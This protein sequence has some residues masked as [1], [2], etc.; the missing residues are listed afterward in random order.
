MT[1]VELF[2]GA[3]GASLG[4]LRAGLEEVRAVEWNRDACETRRAAGLRCDEGDVRDPAH[5]TGVTADA[6][7]S[8]F[9]CQAWSTAGKRLGKDDPRNGWPWTVE[10][11]DRVRPTWFMGENVPGLTF[12]KGACVPGRCAEDCARLYFEGTILR[13]LGERF[14]WV[15]WRILDSARFGVPQNRERLYLVAGPRPIR[16]PEETHA[17]PDELRQGGL[18]GNARRPWVTVR[19][20]LGLRVQGIAT[21]HEA[22]VSIDSRERVDLMHR[23]APGEPDV[24]RHRPRGPLGVVEDPKHPHARPDAPAPTIRSGGA[25]HSSP[26]MWLNATI[27]SSQTSGRAGGRVPCESSIDAP[28]PTVRANEG[29]GLTIR[30]EPWDSWRDKHLRMGFGWYDYA[31]ASGHPEDAMHPDGITRRLVSPVPMPEWARG[32]SSDSTLR[33]MVYTID[34]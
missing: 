27:G 5:Y 10:V 34:G 21:A 23:P 6:V 31:M 8:S 30:I 12:H 17:P 9:P 11:L 3:G 1:V 2:A 20:A 32:T 22:G 25:G 16:W 14:A 24:S 13:D 15:G 33:R 19:E 18:F 29:T 4:L 26:P 7:W 28:A